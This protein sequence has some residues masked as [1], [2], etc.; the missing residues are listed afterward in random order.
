MTAHS[1]PTPTQ[2]QT[3]RAFELLREDQRNRMTMLAEPPTNWCPRRDA[4]LAEVEPDPVAV[5]DAHFG[6][7]A[8]NDVTW[9]QVEMAWSAIR[10]RLTSSPTPSAQMD[11]ASIRADE[12]KK[13]EQEIADAAFDSV[14]LWFADRIRSGLYRNSSS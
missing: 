10:A 8:G 13:A 14:G 11:E 12:R 4:L 7:V 5:L 6:D 9:F 2:E 3:Q 1:R